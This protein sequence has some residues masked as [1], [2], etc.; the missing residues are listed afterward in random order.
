MSMQ[1][2]SET[3]KNKK[4]HHYFKEDIDDR[5]NDYLIKST[6][7]TLK[8]QSFNK[9]IGLSK[10]RPML[11]HHQKAHIHEIRRIS[12][13]IHPQPYKI[14]CFKPKQFSLMNAGE[15]L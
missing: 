2:N 1:A 6:I 11:D 3:R 13:E 12:P 7:V 8:M 4:T 14:R 10:E 9:I 15:G 5:F